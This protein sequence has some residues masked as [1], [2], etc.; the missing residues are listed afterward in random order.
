MPV[1]FW[2]HFFDVFLDKMQK[3][4]KWKSSFRIVKYSVSWG[5]P[6]SKKRAT[7]RKMHRFFHR[8]FVK[9]RWKIAQNACK[10]ALRT[11]IDK[12]PRLECLFFSNKSIF[13]RFL[14]F[15]WVPGGLPGRPGSLPESFVF[16]LIFS[17][18]WKRVRTV[19]REAPGR[20][21]G[22]LRVPFW[23]D[24]WSILHVEQ[25]RKNV[26]KCWRNM[27]KIISTSRKQP[28]SD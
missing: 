19:L 28:N 24:F 25:R 1:E 12:N 17:F 4:K 7:L 13:D 26:E 9:N 22:T 20:P 3:P 14:G 27:A 23:V 2:S 11:K 5:S 18:V 6:C 10:S 8:F 21:R 16:S 15:L